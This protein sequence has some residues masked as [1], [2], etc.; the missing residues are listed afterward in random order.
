MH[1]VTWRH[2]GVIAEPK[3]VVIQADAPEYSQLQDWIR[4]NQSGWDQSYAT[5]TDNGIFVHSGDLHLQFEGKWA[6]VFTGHGDFHKEVRREDYAFL[7][8]LVTP[9]PPW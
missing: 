2:N 8:R 7:R 3:E 5:S 6:S 9:D 1:V 4:H